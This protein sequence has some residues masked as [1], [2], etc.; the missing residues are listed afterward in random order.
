MLTGVMAMAVGV[1]VAGEP[2]GAER[3]AILDGGHMAVSKALGKP[4][5]F[6]VKTLK[7]QG[8][9]AFLVAA[10]QDPHG[11]PIDYTGTPKAAAAAAGAAS[12]DYAALLRRRDDAGWTVVTDAVG[13]TDV[14][15]DGWATE[16]GV[17][18]SLFN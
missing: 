13:P 18:A 4:V 6:L 17:P 2:Q 14:I 11:R 7:R 15:W 1:A 12:K 16:H 8:D 5:R 3:A 9:W 10:M